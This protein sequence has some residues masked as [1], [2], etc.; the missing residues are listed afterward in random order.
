MIMA[1]LKLTSAD[2]RR[3][4]NEFGERGYK[5][6]LWMNQ[7]GYFDHCTNSE[8]LMFVYYSLKQLKE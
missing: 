2:R 6:F 8:E 5:V 4:K 1:T 7:S 3:I